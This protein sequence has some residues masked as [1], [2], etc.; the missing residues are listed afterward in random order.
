M[1]VVVENCRSKSNHQ[2]Q[3]DE[4][5]GVSCYW[6]CETAVRDQFEDAAPEL[7]EVIRRG[8]PVRSGKLA[9]SKPVQTRPFHSVSWPA[10]T[11]AAI[12][13]TIGA[14]KEFSLKK[15]LQCV[16]RFS[17]F[18]HEQFSKNYAIFLNFSPQDFFPALLQGGQN[19]SNG[20]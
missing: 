14:L 7:L 8:T 19:T 12:S 9:A 5:K 11:N 3:C 6:P 4:L 13:T 18:P 10:L 17:C 2:T 15:N 1:D 20:P 16:L